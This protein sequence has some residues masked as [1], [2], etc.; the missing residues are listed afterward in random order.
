M[1]T[2]LGLLLVCLLLAAAS[3]ESWRFADAAEGASLLLGNEAY[4]EGMNE[5][6]L[7]FRLQRRGGTPEELRA[8]AGAQVLDFTDADRAAVDGAMAFLL[9]VCAARGYRLPGWDEAVFVKTTMD[10]ECGAG[11]YTHASQIYLGS[12]ALAFA[13]YDDKR[14]QDFFKE[15]VAHELFHVLT[16]Q[17]PDF[18]RAMYDV[19]GFTVQDGEFPL[20]PAVRAMMIANPDV[21]RH[22]AS[23]VFTIGGEP[24]ECFLV[25]STDRPFE[26][27]GDSFMRGMRTL[28]IPVDAPDTFFD[29]GDAVDFRDVM[30]RNTDYAIDPEEC[31]ATNFA[32]LLLRGPD[33]DFPTQRIPREMDALL[34]AGKWAEP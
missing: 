25:F 14:A 31:L 24:R 12:D 17:N 2:V 26:R 6:D 18:R 4:Y 22:D 20:S 5:E 1:K 28:L 23:A 10:E 27:T 33:G 19:I 32:M 16:R 11:G 30:G 3:A 8:F 9:D 34:R 15:L 21:E 13:R 7:A 29:A